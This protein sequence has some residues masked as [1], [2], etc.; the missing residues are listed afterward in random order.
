MS[1]FCSRYFSKFLAKSALERNCK[2]DAQRQMFVGSRD[3]EIPHFKV[4]V[5]LKFPI[6]KSF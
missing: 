6:S 4:V 1:K 5:T 3:T 2:N